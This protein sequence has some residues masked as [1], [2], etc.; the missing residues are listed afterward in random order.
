MTFGRVRFS[1][2]EL[3]EFLALTELW[4][5]SSMSSF[6][7]LVCVKANSRREFGAE[8]VELFSLPKQCS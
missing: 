5:A 6:W 8:L 4:G 2:T 3:S 7:P 1:N